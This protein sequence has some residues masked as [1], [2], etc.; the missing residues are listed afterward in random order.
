MSDKS[1]KVSKKKYYLMEFLKVVS[2]ILPLL[3]LVTVRHERYIY[4]TWSAV[5][6]SIGGIIALVVMVLTL[7]G[8]LH[9]KGLGLAL[10]GLAL[11][12]FL[13]KL[14]VDIQWIFLCLF[15]GMLFSTIFGICAANEQEKFTIEKTAETTAKQMETVIKK[16]HK[17][18]RV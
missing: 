16:Y 4:S 8:R 11:T 1:G 7:L 10:I 15:V 13:E 3:I 6:F 18:G 2:A 9:I 12:W 14:I 5:R 17:N